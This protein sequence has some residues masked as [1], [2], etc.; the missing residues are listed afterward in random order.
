[1]NIL[2]H[3]F[4]DFHIFNSSLMTVDHQSWVGSLRLLDPT[5][6]FQVGKLRPKEAQVCPVIW[7]GVWNS[8]LVIPTPGTLPICHA[9]PRISVLKIV[10]SRIILGLTLLLHAFHLPSSSCSPSSWSQTP[11]TPEPGT[12]AQGAGPLRPLGCC[13]L[14]L[15]FLLPTLLPRAWERGARV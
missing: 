8:M 14:F 6:S 11:A 5:L 3:L 10:V 13:L 15:L 1:M 2:A 7:W 12:H 9:T 4:G